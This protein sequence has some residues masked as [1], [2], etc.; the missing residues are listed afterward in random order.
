MFIAPGANIAGYV[1]IEEG[2]FIGINATIIDH[3]SIGK[4]SVIAGGAVVIDDVPSNVMV[5]GNPARIVK[6]L[7]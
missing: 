6:K 7:I 1:T 4:Y 3:I 5:A 2:C